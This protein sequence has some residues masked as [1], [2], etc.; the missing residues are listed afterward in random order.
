MHGEEGKDAAVS[1]SGGEKQGEKQD[2]RHLQAE[3][4]GA[5]KPVGRR[6]LLRGAI[7]FQNRIVNG[8]E[9]GGRVKRGGEYQ[10]LYKGRKPYGH[11]GEESVDGILQQ[12]ESP[13]RRFVTDPVQQ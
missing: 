2:H 9:P 10:Y 11:I 5:H 8:E 3:F 1:P 13:Q 12:G 6:I 4:L 7:L